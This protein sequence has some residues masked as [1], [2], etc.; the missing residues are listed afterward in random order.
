MAQTKNLHEQRKYEMTLN[1]DGSSWCKAR[2]YARFPELDFCW[3]KIS[4]TVNNY[5][6]IERGKNCFLVQII[7]I[8]H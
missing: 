5:G 2:N 8:C 1:K 4:G 7:L 6:I 3:W